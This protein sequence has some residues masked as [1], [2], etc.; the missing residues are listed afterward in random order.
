[1]NG[2]ADGVMQAFAPTHLLA[3]VA[4]GLLAGQ[5]APRFAVVALG[6]FALGYTVGTIMI[7]AALRGQ[8]TALVL[9]GIGALSGAAAAIDRTVPQR[10]K[11]I[12]AAAIGGTLAF[13]APPQA[14]TIPSA[15]AEQIGTGIAA[16]ATFALIVLIAM[17]A[18][19]PW[20]RIG[21]RILGSWIAAS[22][23][24]VLVL[25]LARHGTE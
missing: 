13:D 21:V 9:L 18:D 23:L 15:V 17:R 12:A 5:G 24:L 6:A 19:R 7:A 25:R 20:Q 4:L 10:A 8:N 3:V 1:M 22:A 11:E 2:F 14:I 16:L